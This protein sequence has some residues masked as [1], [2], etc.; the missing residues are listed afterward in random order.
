MKKEVIVKLHASFEESVQ[1][2]EDG[3]EYWLVCDR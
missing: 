3:G 1:K 2:D